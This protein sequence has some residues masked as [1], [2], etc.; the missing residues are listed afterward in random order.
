MWHKEAVHWCG[1]GRNEVLEAREERMS[2][3]T[4]R[5][6]APKASG[7]GWKALY[8]VGA[9]AALVAVT[10]FRRNFGIE[11]MQFK[12][13]GIIRGVPAEWPSSAMGW[14][15]LLQDKTFVGLV[16]LN[17]VD[18]A[19]YCLV[20]LMF[21]ALYGALRRVSKGAVMIATV[22]AVVGIGVYF[23][24]NQSLALL[25]LSK[26][27]AEAA[28]DA[29]REMLLAA[30]E[31]LLAIHSQGTGVHL[32]F[33]LVVLAGLILSVIMLRSSVFGK[34]AAIAGIVA[35]ALRVCHLLAL[36]LAPSVWF[37]VPISAPFRVTWYAL[38]AL[39]LF[40]LA[41]DA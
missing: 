39:G 2:Q 7:S 32:S 21:L 23:A 30:G 20:G 14:Y 17:V 38:V 5:S 19:N 4:D 31:A 25:S 37:L 41:H 10:L 12:G 8:I 33:L 36:V 27:Y 1:K 26:Q 40:R 35:N 34:A 18:V 29:Q 11:V 15:A 16:L 24:S 22:C 9:I 6:V 28:T 13:F 3:S